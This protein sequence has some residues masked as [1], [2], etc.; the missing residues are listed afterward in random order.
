M[1]AT[2][3][4]GICCCNYAEGMME[5]LTLLICS[6]MCPLIYSAILFANS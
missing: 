4:I 3:N 6:V 5:D 1:E 2:F